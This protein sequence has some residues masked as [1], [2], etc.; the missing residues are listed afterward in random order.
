M[1]N[2]AAFRSIRLTEK[3]AAKRGPELLVGSDYINRNIHIALQLV[4]DFRSSHSI[5]A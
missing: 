2:P 1:E 4:G 5:A 3:R